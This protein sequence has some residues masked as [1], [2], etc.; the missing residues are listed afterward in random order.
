MLRRVISPRKRVEKIF[1]TLTLSERQEEMK[2][3]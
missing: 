2:K 1:I 3:L